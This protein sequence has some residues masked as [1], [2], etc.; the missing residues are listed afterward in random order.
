MK[1]SY[2]FIGIISIILLSII[3][4]N[5]M[6]YSEPGYV[7]HVRSIGGNEKVVSDI[8]WNFYL[9]GRWNSWKRAMTVQAT[10][11]S[12]ERMAAQEESSQ[13]SANMGPLN[14]I[15]I[16]QV[17]A[18][19]QATVRYSI[20][21]GQVAF[22]HMA[23][24]YR[25]PDNLLRTELIPA[26]KETLRANAAMMSAEDYYLGGQT[27]FN[28]NFTNQMTSGVFLVKRNEVTV[29]AA[30]NKGSANA[31]L[32][33]KQELYGDQTKT[34]FLVEK[35]L[36][37]E[38]QPRRKEQKFTDFGVTVVSARITDMK[39]NKKFVERMQL[40]QKASAD[41]A[42]AREQRIQEEEQRLLAIAKGEREVA[43]R[44]AKAKVDQIEKTT[45]A[46][47]EKQLAVTEAEKFKAQAAIQ[48]DTAQINLEKAKIEAET[49]TTLADAEAYQKE[50]IIKADN[51]LAQ[52]L[53]AE[54]KIQ[55]VWAEAYARRA[56]P[57]TVFGGGQSG[58][59]VGND[60][61]VKAFMQVLTLDAAKRLNY[62]RSLT[63]NSGN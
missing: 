45:N 2:I 48:K 40:K 57:S 60:G 47:T 50:V 63:P 10:R 53:D 21:T 1:K 16:D 15:F 12:V 32:K 59:P 54:I 29:S 62:S 51:A 27:E 9:F 6:F 36:D 18:N 14:I 49:K 26:F 44:Q 28:D 31:S 52:K 56:V 5:S 20:P 23:H 19:A 8:G 43:Q 37:N 58:A 38:G 3:L 17:D 46:E 13:T 55:E 34:I 35:L 61:E 42:I 41:R 25:S 30:P 39:P 22:L 24:E 7:Y 33:D 11:L 4:P